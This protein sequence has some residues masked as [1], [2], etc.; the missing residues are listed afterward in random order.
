VTS[1]RCGYAHVR[2]RTL[3]QNL[4]FWSLS[5]CLAAHSLYRY[6]QVAKTIEE[7]MED[8]VARFGDVPR[9]AHKL[10]D[11]QAKHHQDIW[12]QRLIGEGIACHYVIGYQLDDGWWTFCFDRRDESPDS[13]DDEFWVVEAYDSDGGSWCQG[14]LYSAVS[15]QWT[16]ASADLLATARHPQRGATAY[17]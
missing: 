2:Y 4:F 3:I 11:Y 10:E 12:I 17:P 8:F 7:R 5:C 15:A 13:S 14:F 1:L 9:G 6:G 16:R